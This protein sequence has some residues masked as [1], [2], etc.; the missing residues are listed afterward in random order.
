M[1]AK[2]REIKR[3]KIG[4]EQVIDDW[5]RSLKWW[6]NNAWKASFLS[7]INTIKNRKED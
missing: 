2:V 5:K 7:L 3:L 6:Q 1:L 4:Y